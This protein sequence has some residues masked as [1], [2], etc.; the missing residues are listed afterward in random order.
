[1]T[2]TEVAQIRSLSHATPGTSRAPPRAWLTHHGT[3]RPSLCPPPSGPPRPCTPH[4]PWPCADRPCSH[5]AMA[6]PGPALPCTRA[7]ALTPPHAHT[8]QPPRAWQAAPSPASTLFP[9]ITRSPR[10]ALPHIHI[11]QH[12]PACWRP[13]R[14]SAR[15]PGS[16]SASPHI[17]RASPLMGPSARLMRVLSP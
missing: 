15:G 9:R 11:T 2:F 6:R 4:K 10:H 16:P 17:V 12:L 5:P 14:A 13:I 8:G 3:H 7:L 1:M